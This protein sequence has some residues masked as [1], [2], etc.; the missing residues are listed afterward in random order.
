MNTKDK[1]INS[2]AGDRRTYLS[3]RTEIIKMNTSNLVMG[4]PSPLEI[5]IDDPGATDANGKKW[6]GDDLDSWDEEDGNNE[7]NWG[8]VW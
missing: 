5:P 3:P 6:Q 1:N 2:T 8:S 4:S 7:N